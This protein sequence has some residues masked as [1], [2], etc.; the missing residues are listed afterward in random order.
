MLRREPL[1]RILCCCLL[2]CT[3]VMGT[4]INSDAGDTVNVILKNS[5]STAIE[6]ELI[7]QYGGNFTVTLEAG[8]SQNHTLKMNSE[9]KVK[10]GATHVVTADD[11]G[12]EVSIAS[13]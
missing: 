7:D 6:V 11:E 3:V 12:K 8:S 5:S 2:F 10:G 1:M 13:Q 4:T 9:A